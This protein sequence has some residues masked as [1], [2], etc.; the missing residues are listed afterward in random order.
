MGPPTGEGV[1][2]PTCM[3][4]FYTHTHT[5]THT[6]TQNGN[7][8]HSLIAAHRQKMQMQR[9]RDKQAA[10]QRILQEKE[11]ITTEIIDHGLWLT[12]ADVDD[13]LALIKS[14]TKKKEALKAQIRFPKTVLQQSSEVMDIFKFS[15][16]EVSLT[17]PN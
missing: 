17:R 9:E 1:S 15:N 3:D 10:E 7:I 2:F 12:A 4:F 14:E 16:K 6:H 5:H 11:C 8:V 13:G